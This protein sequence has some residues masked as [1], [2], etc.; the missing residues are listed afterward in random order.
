MP[1]PV[2]YVQVVRHHVCLSALSSITSVR[3]DRYYYHDISWMA[4]WNLQRI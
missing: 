3:P 2:D 1:L 4:W